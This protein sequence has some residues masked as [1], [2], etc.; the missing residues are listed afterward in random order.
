MAAPEMSSNTYN[1]G[2]RFGA[3]YLHE[4]LASAERVAA[5]ELT[6]SGVFTRESS[7]SRV[8]KVVCAAQGSAIPAV[9]NYLDV[10]FLFTIF[11][12]AH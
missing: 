6:R 12:V 7:T 3:G 4:H 8:V 2:E 5:N 9:M 10:S 1:A 11:H